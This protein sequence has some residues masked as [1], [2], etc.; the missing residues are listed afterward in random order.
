[1]ADERKEEGH[2]SGPVRAQGWE[3]REGACEGAEPK[4]QSLRTWKPF[5]ARSKPGTRV[6]L[7]ATASCIGIPLAAGMGAKWDGSHAT[8]FPTREMNE[9]AAEKKLLAGRVE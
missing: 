1:V 4:V 5:C 3:S 8:V 6:R 2:R 7:P 9:I